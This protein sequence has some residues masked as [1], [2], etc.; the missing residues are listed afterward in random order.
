M[1]IYE[2][3]ISCNR[4]NKGVLICTTNLSN[5]IHINKIS[6]NNNPDYLLLE[7]NNIKKN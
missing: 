7:N 2:D 3:N 1:K 4:N 5:I 6:D